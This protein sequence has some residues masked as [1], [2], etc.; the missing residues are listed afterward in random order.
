MLRARV[1]APVKGVYCS[2]LSTSTRTASASAIVNWC[3]PAQVANTWLGN[4]GLGHAGHERY[5]CDEGE[6]DH[7]E[8]IIGTLA[9]GE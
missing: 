9:I 6:V 7:G 3:N 8:E 2:D 1:S 4:K 5:N